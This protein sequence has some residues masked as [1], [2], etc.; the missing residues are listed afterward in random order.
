MR[1][2][3]TLIELLVVIA[4]IAIL[5]ALLLPAVQQAREA[6]RRT[7]CRNNLHQI[8]LAM[9]NYHDTHRC[10]PPGQI[11][12]NHSVSYLKEV[13]WGSV[14]Y[15]AGATCFTMILPFIDETALYNAY[16]FGC[17]IWYDSLKCP[18]NTTV[19]TAVMAQYLCPS[20]VEPLIGGGGAWRE[21]NYSFNEGSSAQYRDDYHGV[22][23]ADMGPLYNRS[24]VRIRDIA[25]GT[26][27]TI[28]VGETRT[29]TSFPGSSP[30][31][32]GT[33]RAPFAGYEDYATG[34][35]ELGINPA[36]STGTGGGAYVCRHQFYSKHEGGAFMLFCDGQVKFLSENIDHGTL[37]ALSTVQGNE[38]IDDEDY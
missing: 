13:G 26:S 19:G 14:G 23:Y 16:N 34:A 4:I 22:I 10:F 24:K 27:N 6:A 2:A 15:A 21:G 37:Q 7:Q 9:H 3:F 18:P 8:G 12:A 36:C 30:Y 38:M 29:G 17:P 32:Y 35:T 31:T 28:L 25:D 20:D 33:R 11:S 5:I 1:R